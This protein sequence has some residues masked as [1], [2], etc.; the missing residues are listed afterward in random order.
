MCN[1]ECLHV[2]FSEL[3]RRKQ[4]QWINRLFDLKAAVIFLVSAAMI[5][6]FFTLKVIYVLNYY[7]QTGQTA[8]S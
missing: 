5:V 4:K 6:T 3:K 7:I 1:D 8:V 2:E